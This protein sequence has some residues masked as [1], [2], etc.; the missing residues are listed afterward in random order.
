[1]I[2]QDTFCVETGVEM[3]HE[4]SF[5]EIA[6][7]ELKKRKRAKKQDRVNKPKS[8]IRQIKDDSSSDEEGVMAE[9]RQ[10]LLLEQS[11]RR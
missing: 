5:L 2:L 1:M 9:Y 7:M 10:M 3:D 8:R 11:V 4:L 6:E